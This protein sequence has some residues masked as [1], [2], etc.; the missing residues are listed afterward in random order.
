VGVEWR[1]K[2]PVYVWLLLAAGVLGLLA[3]VLR[4]LAQRRRTTGES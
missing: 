3:L 1:R 2:T 4:W